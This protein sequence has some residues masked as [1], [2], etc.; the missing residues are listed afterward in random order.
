MLMGFCHVGWNLA[1][2]SRKRW[3]QGFVLEL[4]VVAMAW[5]EAHGELRSE[6]SAGCVCWISQIL[7]GASGVQTAA[8]VG[9]YRSLDGVVSSTYGR[10][11]TSMISYEHP[12]V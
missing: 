6:V 10:C 12:Y 8:V 7:F 5:S 3:I 1:L 4:D 2:P 9:L 11:K